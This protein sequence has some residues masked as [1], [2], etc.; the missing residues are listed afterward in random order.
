MIFLTLE[1]VIG[2]HATIILK[3]G[4]LSGI[5]DVGLLISAVEM[6]KAKIGGLFL[7]YS[8][9]DK[10][11]A[12]LYHITCNDAFLDG[13]KRTA[14]VSTLVFLEMNKVNV[15]INQSLLEALMVK[16]A[17]GRIKKSQI[18]AFLKNQGNVSIN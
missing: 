1:M 13:N 18:S 10:A 17:Q 15:D 6:P 9:Y 8:I 3:K 12:Y 2:I 11:A 14:L 5:R 16:T 4:G 7:H